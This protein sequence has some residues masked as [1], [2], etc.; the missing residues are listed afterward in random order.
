MVSTSTSKVCYALSP[1][2]RIEGFR[3]VRALMTLTDRNG[4][5][6]ADAEIAVVYQTAAGEPDEPDGWTVLATWTSTVGTPKPVA[7][8][9]TVAGK[10]WIRFGIAVRNQSASQNNRASASLSVEGRP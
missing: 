1:W 2:M 7:G 8:S 5:A 9:P 10:Y 6:S 4:D 3:N